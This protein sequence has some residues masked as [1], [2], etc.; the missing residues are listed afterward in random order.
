MQRK[1]DTAVKEQDRPIVISTPAPRPKE[2]DG[3]SVSEQGPI[4]EVPEEV[5]AR[6]LQRILLFAFVP[7]AFGLL[8]YPFFYYLKVSH[9]KSLLYQVVAF[10]GFLPTHF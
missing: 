2:P 9:L 1:K 5:N 10:R 4:Q 6:L 7:V 8:L 3:Q